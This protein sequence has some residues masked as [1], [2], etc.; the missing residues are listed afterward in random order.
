MECALLHHQSPLLESCNHFLSPLVV[1][2]KGYNFWMANSM[3]FPSFNSHKQLFLHQQKVLLWRSNYAKSKHSFFTAAFPTLHRTIMACFRIITLIAVASTASE[4]IIIDKYRPWIIQKQFTSFD[5]SLRSHD[6]AMI[7]FQQSRM[8][9]T[10]ISED[11]IKIEINNSQS[12][13]NYY[14]VHHLHSLINGTVSQKL[15]LLSRWF[16]D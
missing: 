8:I 12:A 4:I 16:G 6:N 5:K 11:L 9:N 10:W 3:R 14:R 7:S 15:H 1:A 2:V 13:E